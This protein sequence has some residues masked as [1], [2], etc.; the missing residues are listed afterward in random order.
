MRALVTGSARGIGLAIAE[1]LAADGYDVVRLDLTG[2]GVVACDI[3]DPAAVAAAAEAVGPVDVL[4]NNAGL[5]KQGA[6]LDAPLEDLEAVVDV[7][8]LGTLHCTRAFGAGM[9][10][11]GAGAIVNIASIS[12][13]APSPTVG[14]Y[15]ASKAAVVGLTRQTALEWGP[16][17]VRCNA[18]GPGMITTESNQDAYADEAVLRG[19]LQAIPLR[20]LGTGEDIAEVVAFL[21]SDKAAYVT[22]Q[23]LYV[24]GGLTQSL[25]KL[26]PYRA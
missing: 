15:T 24:D 21:V 26:I 16:H 11:R 3:T 10:E 13:I 20:R 25:F 12:A 7:N 2:D 9:V 23:V 14:M 18:V 22:G 8:L 5:W 19:R 6:L 17:G 1:R 4:V